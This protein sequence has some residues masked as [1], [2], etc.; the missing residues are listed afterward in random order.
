MLSGVILFAAGAFA[1]APALHALIVGGGP[2]KSH[3]QVAIESNV[4]YL[5]R[6]LPSPATLHVLFTD[7]NPQSENVQCQGEDQKIYY[8]APQLPRLDGP[9]KSPN[10]RSELDA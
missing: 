3:N 8:R 5:G 2:D 4:R 1:P 9:S 6:M 7:G 10:V